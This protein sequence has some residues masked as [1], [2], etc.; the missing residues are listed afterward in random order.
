M[1]MTFDQEITK[2]F[3]HERPLLPLLLFIIGFA[4]VFLPLD[5]IWAGKNIIITA[6]GDT[7]LSDRVIYYYLD[8]LKKM[9]LK[10]DVVIAN[11]EG[12][13]SDERTNDE[14]VFS[15]PLVTCDI[16]QRIG[17]NTLNLANNHVMDLGEEQYRYTKQKLIEKDF[18]VAGYDDKGTTLKIDNITIRII[19]FSFCSKNNVKQRY[20]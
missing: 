16:L 10:G 18:F 2:Q 12:V 5:S 3:P 9:E 15:M 7:R 14:W 11:F 20:C 6:V 17:I 19:G 1:S 4:I 13:L 8:D